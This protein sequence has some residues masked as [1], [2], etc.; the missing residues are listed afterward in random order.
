MARIKMYN[1]KDCIRNMYE[2]TQDNSGC[3]AIIK[4]EWFKPSS[5]QPDNQL[6]RLNYGFGCR[7][8]AVG[9]ACYGEFCIDGEEVRLERYD[10]IGIAG[11][12]AVE[13]ALKLEQERTTK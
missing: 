8:T 2:G 4:P 11:T 5:R 12:E 10:F 13:R 3:I 6:F 9:N 1:D 7:P